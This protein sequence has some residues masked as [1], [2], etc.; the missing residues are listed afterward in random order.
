MLDQ[1]LNTPLFLILLFSMSD[2]CKC[3]TPP[4]PPPHRNRVLIWNQSGFEKVVFLTVIKAL[5]VVAMAVRFYICKERIEHDQGI[6][7][8]LWNITICSAK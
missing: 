4:P 1:A 7:A 5:E 6:L 8:T 2:K 3:M